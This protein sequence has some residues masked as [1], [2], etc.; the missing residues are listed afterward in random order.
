MKEKR[1]PLIKSCFYILISLYIVLLLFPIYWMIFSSIE[2][3]EL[4]FTRPA[5]YFPIEPTIEHW[6]NAFRN[7]PFVHY[8]I[9]SIITTISSAIIALFFSLLAAYAFGRIYFRGR[10][11][12]F[13]MLLATMMFPPITSVIPLFRLYNA[14]GLLDTLRGLIII[15]SSF[16]IPFGTWILVSF[17]KQ[18]PTELDDAARVDGC[19]T[20]SIIFRIIFPLMK[21]GITTVLLINCIVAWN[22][23]LIP[24]IF[25]ASKNSKT[26]PLGLVEYH[27]PIEFQIPY[28]DI[29]AVGVAILIPLIVVVIF[30]R[31][32]LVRGLTLGGVKGI[33]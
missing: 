10:R 6:L 26:L 28:G 23:F 24:L 13:I 16:L 32:G 22:E 30:A 17:V 21:P 33:E 14:V 2:T 15:Y 12:L 27:A 25:A 8:T 29:S 4:L 31:K 5:H 1:A 18:I 20:V 19:S 11:F 3:S 7:I 9:N